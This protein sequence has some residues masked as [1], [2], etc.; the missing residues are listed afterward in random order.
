MAQAHIKQRQ[1]ITMKATDVSLQD[2]L[3]LPSLRLCSLL[4]IP[5]HQELVSIPKEKLHIT[6]AERP[7]TYVSEWYTSSVASVYYYEIY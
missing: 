2:P 3:A 7:C 6:G 5:M 4:Q 1:S